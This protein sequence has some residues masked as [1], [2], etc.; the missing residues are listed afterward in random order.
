MVSNILHSLVYI[1]SSF[2]CELNELIIILRIA[3]IPLAGLD[4]LEIILLE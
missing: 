2:T 1:Y 3:S 4:G